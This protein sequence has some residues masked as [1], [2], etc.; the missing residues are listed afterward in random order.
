VNV[1]DLGYNKVTG[2]GKVTKKL[3]VITRLITELAKKKIEKAGGIVEIVK[4]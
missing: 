4:K 2:R 1:L 3:K